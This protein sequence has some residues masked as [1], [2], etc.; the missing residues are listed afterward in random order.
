MR[1]IPQTAREISISGETLHNWIRQAEI[2][3]GDREGLA[4][5]S[6]KS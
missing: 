2:G 4:T 3:E 1:S 6:T 5:R